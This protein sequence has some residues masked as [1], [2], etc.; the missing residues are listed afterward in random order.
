MVLPARRF[1]NQSFRR[2]DRENGRFGPKKIVGY[3]QIRLAYNTSGQ[4]LRAIFSSGESVDYR[5]DSQEQLQA[6]RYSNGRVARCTYNP[7]GRGTGAEDLTT[8]LQPNVEYN[9][10]RTPAKL[11]LNGTPYDLSYRPPLF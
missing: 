10:R 3:A 7:S 11:T 9:E 1:G 6:A 8:T 2:R 5:H 4:M